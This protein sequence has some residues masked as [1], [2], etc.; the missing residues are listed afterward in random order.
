MC[1]KMVGLCDLPSELLIE[2]LRELD[3]TSKKEARL[4]CRQWAGAGANCL[5]HRVYYAPRQDRINIFNSITENTTFAANFTELVYDARLFCHGVLEDRQYRSYYQGSFP[6]SPDDDGKEFKFIPRTD[7][8]DYLYSARVGRHSRERASVPVTGGELRKSREK[9]ALCLRHQASILGTG[10]DFDT[11]CMGMKRLPNLQQI[12]ILDSFEDA[13][14]ISPFISTQHQWYREWSAAQFTGIVE[15]SRLS[16]LRQNPFWDF[17]GIQ[18]LCKAVSLYA[19]K[20]QNLIFGC[21][22][23]NMSTARYSK[24]NIRGMM[25]SIVPRL[26]KFKVYCDTSYYEIVDEQW[27]KDIAS[28]LYEGQQLNEMAL[29]LDRSMTLKGKWPQ[30]RVLEFS[31]GHLDLPILKGFS[32]FHADVLREL[33]LDY[34]ELR[35]KHSWEEVAEEIGQYWKLN[36]LSLYCLIDG[37]DSKELVGDVRR[38][39]T[40]ARGFMLRIPYDDLSMVKTEVAVVAW[41]KQNYVPS[42]EFGI[43]ASSLSEYA[44]RD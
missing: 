19:P 32:Q 24:P 41:D 37:T 33:T 29:Y 8:E 14:D 20:V 1:S 11:L 23:R 5:S 27:S 36:L 22:L 3:T 35:G 44:A 25:R 4:T 26:R 7:G 39:E 2:V 13:V 38:L 16:D 31:C 30:L 28:L 12:S 18:N 15:P 9:Y 21:E 40:I 42:P 17:R 10:Q 43:V 34:V 6:H